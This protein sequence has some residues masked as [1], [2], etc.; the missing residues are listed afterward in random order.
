MNARTSLSL[1][2]I[3]A[4]ALCCAGHYSDLDARIKHARTPA[5]I[6]KVLASEP[7][8]M[9]DSA[10][11]EEYKELTTSPEASAKRIRAIV[12]MEAMAENA[13]PASN[14]VSAIQSIKSPSIYHDPGLKEDANWLTRSIERLKNLFNFKAKPFPSSNRGLGF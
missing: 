2:L 14:A 3:A 12:D 8:I 11:R 6:Q 7:A 1:S 10:I 5:E 13:R 9:S 4:C